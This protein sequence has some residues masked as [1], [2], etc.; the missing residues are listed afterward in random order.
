[1]SEKECFGEFVMTEIVAG[2]AAILSFWGERYQ[3]KVEEM[4]PR[5]EYEK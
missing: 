3:G 2:Q 5:I 4:E 1:M